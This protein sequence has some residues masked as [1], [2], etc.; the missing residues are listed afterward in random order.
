MAK[1][2]LC[3]TAILAVVII[4]AVTSTPIESSE[5]IRD[6]TDIH[7]RVSWKICTEIKFVFKSSK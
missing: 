4:C 1:Y 7:P 3:I 2:F 6:G 5:E